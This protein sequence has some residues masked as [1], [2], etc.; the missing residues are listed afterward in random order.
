MVQGLT[1]A[2][3][4]EAS[5]R[6]GV[7]FLV[8]GLNLPHFPLRA[9]DVELQRVHLEAMAL[10]TVSLDR[11]GISGDRTASGQPHTYSSRTLNRRSH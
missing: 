9:P 11:Q 5:A 6:T 1:P 8:E 10:A 4:L 2:R 7:T 3:D